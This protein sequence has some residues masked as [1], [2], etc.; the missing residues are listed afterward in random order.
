MAKSSSALSYPPPS[1]ADDRP[2]APLLH[3]VGDERFHS[4]EL[5]G[6]GGA[7]AVAHDD[8]ADLLR[9]DA[10][11][12]VDRHA[13]PLQPREVSR[14]RGPVDV[15][16]VAALHL[17]LDALED[18][19]IERRDRRALAEHVE[20]HALAHRALRGPIHDERHVRV[21]VQIDEARR[22]DLARRVDDERA[23]APIDRTD[24][25]DMAAADA[26]IGAIARA[27]AAVDDRSVRDDDVVL[28]RRLGEHHDRTGREQRGKWKRAPHM[29]PP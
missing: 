3:R 28:R 16:V 9:R 27:A 10:R 26:D 20:R 29:M 14:H 17:R 12:H 25:G 7:L 11:R 21:C 24:R 23:G 4:R 6:R 18:D 1:Y 22:N 2:T 15:E 5:R 8:A 13:L 19:P